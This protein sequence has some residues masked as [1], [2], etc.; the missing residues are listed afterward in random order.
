MKRPSALSTQALLTTSGVSERLG[1]AARWVSCV[2]PNAHDW[3]QRLADADADADTSC[4]ECMN[5]VTDAL[6]LQC[7]VR[8]GRIA[9][10]ASHRRR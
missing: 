7:T 9:C 5:D 1:G 4:I 3:Q 8:R 2:C 10:I 6:D